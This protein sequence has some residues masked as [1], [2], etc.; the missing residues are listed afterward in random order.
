MCHAT[1]KIPQENMKSL[2]VS[3][4]KL[5][6]DFHDFDFSRLDFDKNIVPRTY[7]YK[8]V[9]SNVKF[10]CF[11]FRNYNDTNS[12]LGSMVVTYTLPYP[13]YGGD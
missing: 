13:S 4:D 2:C 11:A 7:T 3:K 5:G 10:V 12:I 9:L 8:R 6:F 1:N